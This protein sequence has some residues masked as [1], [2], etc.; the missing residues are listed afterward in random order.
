MDKSLLINHFLKPIKNMA[1]GTILL[2]LSILVSA[3]GYVQPDYLT[4]GVAGQY[5]N[6]SQPRMFL[7]TVID[8]DDE[9]IGKRCEKDLDEIT[10]IFEE[11]ADWLDM[12]MEEPKIIKGDQF[13]KTAVNDAIDDWLKSQEPA[14][15]D[16]VV[17][18][19][20]GHGFRYSNDASNYPRM[21][22]KT[23]KD[24]NTETT[25][26]RMEEDI[27]DR[28]V[29]MGAGVNI[30]LSD[31]CNTT[32][33]GDNAYFDKISIPTR[34]RVAHKREQ[35]KEGEPTDEIDNAEK[36]FIPDQPLSIL[37]TAAGRDEFAGG[38]PEI[39]G[40]FTYYFLE[41]LEECIYETKLEPAWENIFKYANEKAG[42]WARSADCPKAKHNE[43]GR[44]IQTAT[45]KMDTHH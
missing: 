42:Y 26:L 25:N 18:Y 15:I 37:A 21:W 10:Y 22:L 2:L 36:L 7:I 3:N 28:I 29:K 13:S 34:K 31:C 24:Q 45:F 27:Y 9:S 8:S 23:S 12:K 39:G 30:V 41:A 32:I 38:K 5:K 19:Y 14:K 40:L 44:C 1:A 6:E 11:L 4:K 35:P 43:Q 20:S 33:T 16:L 17:F